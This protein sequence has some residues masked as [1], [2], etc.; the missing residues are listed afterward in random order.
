MLGWSQN[1]LSAA[2]KVAKAT[3]ANF[4]ADRR[5]PYDRT[6]ADLRSALEAAGIEF[7]AENGGGPGVRLKKGGKSVQ[8][9]S[10][11]IDDLTAEND[12]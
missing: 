9:A 2:S 8:T 6:L 11:P 10:I 3:I 4:E 7:I 12:E 1:Q 5:T